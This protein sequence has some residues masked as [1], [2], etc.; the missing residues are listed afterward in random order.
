MHPSP[1]R[2]P[3]REM[4]EASA[5]K[6]LKSTRFRVVAAI[7]VALAVALVVWLVARPGDSNSKISSSRTQP[8][9]ASVGDL[10]SV[11]GSLKHQLYWIGQKSGFTYEL[12]KAKSGNV[13]VRYLP[14][15]TQIGDTRANFL[16]VGTYPEKNA[17][18]S[19]QAATKRKGAV[20][21]TTPNGGAAVRYTQR[22]SSIF[23]AYP[24]SNLLIEVFDP[25]PQTALDVVTSG[26]LRT[27]G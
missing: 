19:V 23:V 26:A 20:A 17:F 12:T 9:A 22:P 6:P 24:G 2:D 16:T 13:W 1:T 15:G 27:I 7:G 11:A 18:Q 5:T 10:A 21:V 4:I 8:V 14:T 3:V 25:S